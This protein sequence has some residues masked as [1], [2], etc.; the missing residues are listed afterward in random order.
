MKTKVMKI[1]AWFDPFSEAKE[2]IKKIEEIEKSG[3]AFWAK[4]VEISRE[5]SAIFCL[6][7]YWR[8]MMKIW[9]LVAVFLIL[10]WVCGK[11]NG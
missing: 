10:P 8:G 2:R 3:M 1:L 7:S 5:I 4:K 9:I 6:R 11:I